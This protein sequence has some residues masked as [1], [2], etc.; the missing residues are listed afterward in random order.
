MT[1]KKREKKC[2]QLLRTSCNRGDVAMTMLSYHNYSTGKWT[3]PQSNL[4]HWFY[5]LLD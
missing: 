5:E 2:R 1:K 4:W 3:L